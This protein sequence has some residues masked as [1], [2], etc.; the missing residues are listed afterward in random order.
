MS[1]ICA[2]LSRVIT[3][4]AQ[5]EGH[6]AY[7]NVFKGT[8]ADLEAKFAKSTANSVGYK[9]GDLVLFCQ[10]DL[11]GFNRIERSFDVTFR[12][13][14]RID[15]IKLAVQEFADLIDTSEGDLKSSAIHCKRGG[16][17]L[18]FVGNH[19]EQYRRK[20]EARYMGESLLHMIES[21]QVKIR[22]HD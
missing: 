15:L 20:D 21:N 11:E 5:I 13:D 2:S 8:E 18:S 10:K 22:A 4:N 6:S 1:F 16:I 19:L 3:N 12:S 17:H 14:E 7:I 9:R